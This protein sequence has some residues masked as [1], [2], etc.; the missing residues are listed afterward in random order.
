LH[1]ARFS[2]APRSGPVTVDLG[3]T[4]EG[5]VELVFRSLDQAG[6]P[7]PGA[8][9]NP[10]LANAAKY[11]QRLPLKAEFNVF[12]NRSVLP[13]AFLVRSVLPARK[14]EALARMLAPTF[15]PASTAVIENPKLGGLSDAPLQSGEGVQVVSY[16]PEA[17]ELAAAAATIRLLVLTDVYFPGWRLWVDG[18]EERIWPVDYAFRGV[19]LDRGQHRI[20]MRY[21]PLSFHLGLW[22]TLASLL[23]LAVALLAGSFRSK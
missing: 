11:F 5:K 16:T 10:S 12:E 8:L 23:C 22:I 15:D 6:R 17:V 7:A 4:G 9:V 18:A 19:I 1:F 3:R 21:E 13:P 2:S 20:S 14:Q